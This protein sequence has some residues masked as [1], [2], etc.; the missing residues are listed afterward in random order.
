MTYLHLAKDVKSSGKMY[1]LSP[2]IITAA[3][4]LLATLLALPPLFLELTTP[5]FIGLLAGANFLAL[6]FGMFWRLLEN[7]AA[8][9]MLH[10]RGNRVTD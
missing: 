9:R 4:A 8:Y 7:S 6:Q 3:L 2:K 1:P 10:S 5:R